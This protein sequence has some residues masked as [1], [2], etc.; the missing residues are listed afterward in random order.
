MGMVS[1]LDDA[2]NG[3]DGHHFQGYVYYETILLMILQMF[4]IWS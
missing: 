4:I 1:N 2:F 3:Y